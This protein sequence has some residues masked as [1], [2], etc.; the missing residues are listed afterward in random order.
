[1]AFFNYKARD[2]QG[3][4]ITGGLEAVDKGQLEAA[5]DGMGLI[6][7]RVDVGMRLPSFAVSKIY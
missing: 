7:I 3:A 2:R 1:M 4:L 5:L 6:P